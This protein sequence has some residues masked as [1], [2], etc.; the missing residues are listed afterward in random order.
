MPWAHQPALAVGTSSK[1]ST[2]AG[3]WC[4]LDGI[5]PIHRNVNLANYR[6][7]I[8]ISLNSDPDRAVLIRSNFSSRLPTLT[9]RR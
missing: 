5:S 4:L 2:R 1:I 8:P 3:R 9:R 7:N 6:L